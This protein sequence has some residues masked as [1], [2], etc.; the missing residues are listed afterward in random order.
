MTLKCLYH[1]LDTNRICLCIVILN[2]RRIRQNTGR[3]VG[4]FTDNYGS[5]QT[6]VIPQIT[7]LAVS[8][9]DK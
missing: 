3:I 1:F 5:A 6:H 7:G 4:F 9:I 8:G 2:V